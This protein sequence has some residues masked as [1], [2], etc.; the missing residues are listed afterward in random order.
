MVS[1][2]VLDASVATAW[3]FADETTPE[4]DALRDS[5]AERRALVPR[6]W[7]AETTNLL[8]MAER[9][10]RIKPERCEEL[11]ELLAALP[12]DT[13][14]ETDRMRG[15]VLRMA[16]AHRL[17]VYDAVYLDLAMDRGLTLATRDVALQKAARA[18]GVVL[19]E[20]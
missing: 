1:S 17:S 19:I 3:C 7:H 9:R 14:D 11:L 18:E 10:Q 5:L 12:I 2:F 6:L 16:R 20:T 4:S 15:P 13:Q 8:L